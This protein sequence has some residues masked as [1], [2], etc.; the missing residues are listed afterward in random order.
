[1]TR[2]TWTP[3]QLRLLARGYG[4]GFWLDDMKQALLYAAAVIDAAE[5][6]LHSI[7]QAID[8]SKYEHA[9]G[10]TLLD[11]AMEALRLCAKARGA[12]KENSNE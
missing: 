2:R 3:E 12:A 10:V 5:N 6:A 11:T 4:T 8:L 1:M 9:P 7:D